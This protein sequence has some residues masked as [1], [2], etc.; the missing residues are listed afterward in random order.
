VLTL[1]SSALQTGAWRCTL[2]NTGAP[3]PRDVLP[4]VFEIFFSTKAGGSGIGLA[5]CQRIV[6]EHGGAIS[7]E[8]SADR[9]T[10]VVVTLPDSG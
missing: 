4:H 5:L 3:I 6:D 10:H 7:I 8:S 9:G 1:E 2:H